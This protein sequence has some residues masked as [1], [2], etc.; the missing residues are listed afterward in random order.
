MFCCHACGVELDLGVAKV[1]GRGDSCPQCRAPLHA[2]RNCHAY[3]DLARH[4]CR[5]PQ[6]EPPRDKD[7]GNFCELFVFR[8]GAAKA[9]EVDPRAE[10]M[11]K[12]EALFK[13]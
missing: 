11:A 9:K 6:A 10:A 4:G 3:D 5:E 2:C 1:A 13:K 7:A 12:L 8:K